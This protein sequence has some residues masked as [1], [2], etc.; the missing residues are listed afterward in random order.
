MTYAIIVP[1]A[2]EPLTLAQ[3]K[4]HLRLDGSAEDALLTGLIAAAR[5]YLEADTGL[6]LIS[7]TLRFYLD[8]WPTDGLIQLAISPLQ[9]LESVTVYDASGNAQT[10]PLDGHVLDAAAMPARL[11]LA[12]QPPTSRPLNGIEIDVRAGFGDTGTDVPDALQRAMQMHI[13]LMYELRG[14]VPAEMQPAAVPAGYDRL[15]SPWRAVR[16]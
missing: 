16:L 6:A 4:L 8:D 2:V 11:F 10:V 1:P 12:T 13:A 5:Q 3:V 15:V 9:T 14:A 7:R